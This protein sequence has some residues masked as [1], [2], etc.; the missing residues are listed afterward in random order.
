MKKLFGGIELNLRKVIILAVIAGVYTGIMAMV[1][2]AKDT[3]FE[4][5]TIS[6]E[7]WVLFGVLLIVNSKS[8]KDSAIN[9]FVFFLVS[10]PLVYLVQVPFSELGWSLMSYYKNWIIWTILTIP[11]GFIGWY[12]KLD[13]WWG[14]CILMPMVAFVGVFYGGFVAE[15]VTFFPLKLYSCIFCLVTMII[16]PLFVFHDGRIRKIGLAISCLLILFF[17]VIGIMK[18]ATYETTL[19]LSGY[20]IKGTD[21]KVEFDETYDVYFSDS[22]FGEVT[23]EEDVVDGTDGLHVVFR[24]LGTVNIILESPEGNKQEITVK[25]SRNQYEISAA[26]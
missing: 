17:T 4:D 2:F 10:Q 26:R 14:L 21:I 1:P 7:R 18:K 8:P 24:K 16:Y 9:C 3:S 19:F 13:K 12:M 25:V 20:Q 11:M 22:R 23:I 6:F 15:T 5:I